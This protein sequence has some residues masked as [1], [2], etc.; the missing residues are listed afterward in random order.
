MILSW[1]EAA[2]EDYLN[3]QRTDKKILKPIHALIKGIKRQ[4]FDGLGDPK[5]LKHNCQVIGLGV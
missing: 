3:W 5:P 1:P 4:P 2:W